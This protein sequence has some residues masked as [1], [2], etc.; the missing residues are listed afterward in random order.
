MKRKF[1][2]W[3][4]TYKRG[5]KIVRDLSRKERIKFIKTFK[6]NIMH[7]LMIGHNIGDYNMQDSDLE[8]F[9]KLQKDPPIS[10]LDELYKRYR[11]N[12]LGYRD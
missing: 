4:Y 6:K 11:G 1:F 8:I 12:D 10:K 7:D 5:G 3:W 9:I 2:V